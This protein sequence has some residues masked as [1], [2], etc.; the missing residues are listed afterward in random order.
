M[1]M[2]KIYAGKHVMHLF[3]CWK[4]H[5][6]HMHS[7][8]DASLRARCCL[9]LCER[10]RVASGQFPCMQTV[11]SNSVFFLPH[12]FSLVDTVWGARMGEKGGKKRVLFKLMTAVAAKG[13]YWKEYIKQHRSIYPPHNPLFQHQSAHPSWADRA[14]HHS[15]AG[16]VRE[17]N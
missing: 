4:P 7:H 13:N 16:W 17:D 6:T 11:C 2:L 9:C 1:D 3:A 12:F 8:T 10:A 5:V 14:P 15:S